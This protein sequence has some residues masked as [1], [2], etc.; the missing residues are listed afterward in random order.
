MFGFS[1]LL[2]RKN[3]VFQTA[4]DGKRKMQSADFLCYNNM[5]DKFSDDK[6]FYEDSNF[7]LVLDGVVLNKK[8]LIKGS[9]DWA[10]ALIRLYQNPAGGGVISST[11]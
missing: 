9:D 6:V 11:C 5:I 2:N 3:L 4:G 10:H 7:A 8:D 1:A